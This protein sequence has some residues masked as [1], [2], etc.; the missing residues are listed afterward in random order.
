LLVGVGID[1]LY[2]PGVFLESQVPLNHLH[3]SSFFCIYT[4]ILFVNK[5][6]HFVDVLLN[7]FRIF[8]TYFI[9]LL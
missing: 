1:A 7:S 8:S 9:P 5:F 6:Y 4:Y 3:Q 2:L